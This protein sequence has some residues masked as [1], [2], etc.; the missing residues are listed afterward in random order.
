MEARH[1]KQLPTEAHSRNTHV[2][3]LRLQPKGSSHAGLA[4][5]VRAAEHA[6]WRSGRPILLPGLLTWLRARTRR[7]TAV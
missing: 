3:N 6:F 2:P 4:Y 5:P 7:G 1:A